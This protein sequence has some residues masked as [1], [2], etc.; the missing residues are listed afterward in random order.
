VTTT[1]IQTTP[2]ACDACDRA[3][4]PHEA[5]TPDGYCALC[6]ER[7]Y[8]AAILGGRAVRVARPRAGRDRTHAAARVAEHLPLDPVGAAVVAR[9][10]VAR[11]AVDTLGPLAARGTRA[12]L[13]ALRKRIEGDGK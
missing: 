1:P 3:L 10:E 4:A 7:C 12:L 5:R 8:P 2:C 9:R 11:V 13:D 6:A